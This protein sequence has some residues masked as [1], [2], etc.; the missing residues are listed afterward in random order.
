MLIILAGTYYDSQ[1]G[2]S[3]INSDIDK[4]LDWWSSYVIELNPR[5]TPQ[6]KTALQAMAAEARSSCYTWYNPF[7][8]E[9]ET[10]C[11]WQYL[12]NN[13]PSITTD[14]DIMAIL[15][16]VAEV[17]QDVTD[18]PDSMTNQLGRL[19]SGDD[20]VDVPKPVKTIFAL[21]AVAGIIYLLKD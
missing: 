1:Y 16:N 21:A 5:L 17:S 12:R 11:F 14:S 3:E 8:S 4:A 18:P 6:Q 20:T 2:V 7:D 9:S 15:G 10:L 13:V 19:L